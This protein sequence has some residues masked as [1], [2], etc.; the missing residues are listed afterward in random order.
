MISPAAPTPKSP[1]RADHVV[2]G[3]DAEHAQ[4]ALPSHDVG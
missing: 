2:I 3:V 4:L 1:M